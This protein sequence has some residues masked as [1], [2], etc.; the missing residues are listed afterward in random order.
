MFFGMSFAGTASGLSNA[1]AT[2]NEISTLTFSNVILDELYATKKVLVKFNWEIPNIWDFDTLLHARYKET[3]HAGNIEFNTET[4]T[5]VKIKRRFVGDFNWR[6][7]YEQEVNTN[8]DFEIEFY[9]YYEPSGR[10]I[11]Y[12]YAINIGGIDSETA[13]G[14]MKSEFA[15]YFIC[16]QNGESYPMILDVD[17]A[18]TYNRESQ[19]VTS[20]GKKYPYVINNGITQYYSGTLKVNFVQMT[21]D[22]EFN[23][24]DTWKYRNEID[25]FL[26]NGEPK[27]LKS[28]EGDMWLVDVTNSISR[29]TNGHYQNV[30]HQ[31]DWVEIGDPSSIGDLYDNGFINT[32]ADRE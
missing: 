7:I 3:L 18:I 19:I 1:T 26:A 15:H 30:V 14:E 23:W 21:D 25:Q 22:C 20:P 5:S 13:T 4:T 11:E 31:F 6:T 8:K 9:D 10:T 32:D 24:D 17:N 29:N 12:A 16:G 27:I 28:F 2:K